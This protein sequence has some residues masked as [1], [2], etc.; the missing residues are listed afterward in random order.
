MSI[1]PKQDGPPPGGFK[2]I[3]WKRN[4]PP[5]RF[6][7]VSLFMIAGGLMSYGLYRLV[8]GNQKESEKRKQLAKE[9]TEAMEKWQIEYNIKT[10]TGMRKALDEQMAQ[11]G[12]GHH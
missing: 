12:D 11:G 4:I 7:G 2:P 8:K 5:S 1:P 10:F 6:N 3:S 9:R